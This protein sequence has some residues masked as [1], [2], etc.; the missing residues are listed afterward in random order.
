MEEINQFLLTKNQL[1][2]TILNEVINLIFI[3]HL[4]E[5]L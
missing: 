5:F 4:K 1:I 3:S 2:I